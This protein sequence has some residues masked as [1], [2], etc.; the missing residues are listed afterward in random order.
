MSGYRIRQ[1]LLPVLLIPWLA[2][3]LPTERSAPRQTIV[4]WPEQ[5]LLFIADER[6]GSVRAF[7]LGGAPVPVAQTRT[8]ERSSV[9]DIQ[10]DPVRGRLWVLGADAA[11]V[12]DAHRLA[13]QKRIPLD[14]RDVAGMRI[15]NGG[16]TLLASSNRVL[17]R[18]DAATLLALWHPALSVRRG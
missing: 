6:I 16:V 5:R 18:I 1:C 9:R 14:A 15:E 13:L 11:Y 7:H 8:F 12:H 2:A 17:G 10:L 3:C 4:E